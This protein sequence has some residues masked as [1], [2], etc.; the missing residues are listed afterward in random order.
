MSTTVVING[1]NYY[2]PAVGEN[3]WGQ[4]VTDALVA[5]T[6]AAAGAGGFLNRVAVSSSPITVVSGRTYLVDTS[7]A[8]TLN[9][10]AP[11]TNA[12]LLVKDVTGQAQTN[13][14]TI[15]RNGSESIDGVAANKTL[16]INYGFWMFV[17]DGTDWYL[18]RDSD[19]ALTASRAMVT[20]AA[21]R[22]SA[23]SVT[24][25][26]LGYLDATSSVQTQLDAK[27]A[28]AGGTMA[29]NIAM[30]GNKVT[31]LGA[32][33]ANGDALRYEQLIGAYLPLAGGTMTGALLAAAGTAGAPGL[34]FDANTGLY[35][36]GANA[37][38]FAANG[39]AWMYLNS[40]GNLEFRAD[41]AKISNRSGSE[42]LP[43]YAFAAAAAYGMYYAANALRFSA[44]GTNVL[45]MSAS[46]ITTGAP[47]N[48]KGT[49]TN[50]AAAAGY[51][52]ERIASTVTNASVGSNG[53]YHNQTSISLTAGDWDVSAVVYYLKNGATV[54]GSVAY[55]LGITAS[56]ANSDAGMVY[57]DS[58]IYCGTPNVD[59]NISSCALPCVRISVA[60]TTTIYMK[61]RAEYSA[62][63]PQC[64][65]RISARRVR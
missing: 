15:A 5:L 35:K 58:L 16:N 65:G 23:S 9:L 37:L 59:N 14:I 7:A 42:A 22:A 34:A 38:G 43:S 18:L 3:N 10:P 51:V 17:C 6:V 28:K 2:I 47:T 21:G 1:L 52:G 57:G 25:T 45:T 24:S 49:D 8:R 56:S 39:T 30:G 32:G 13:N 20:D 53:A 40:D 63:T 36:P 26:T 11:A 55:M 12:Y 64:S 60:S 61:T 44:N 54:S 29:G 62:G 41:S 48:V 50:D 31:G 19:A 27:L 4:N 46:A 33:T